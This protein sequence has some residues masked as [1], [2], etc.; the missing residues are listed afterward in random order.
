[1][2]NTPTPPRRW[3]EGASE[4]SLRGLEGRVSRKRS[5]YRRARRRNGRPQGLAAGRPAAG[6]RPAGR[7]NSNSKNNTTAT[8]MMTHTHGCIASSFASQPGLPGGSIP[9]HPLRRPRSRPTGPRA[10]GARSRSGRTRPGRCRPD[11]RTRAYSRRSR[12]PRSVKDTC[13]RSCR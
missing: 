1:M 6:R 7:R 10:A 12:A 3:G 5:Q 13:P 2:S 9:T 4:Y 8:A 11:G